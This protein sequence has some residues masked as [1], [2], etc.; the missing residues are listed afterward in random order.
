MK[1]EKR[2][3]VTVLSAEIE[4]PLCYHIFNAVSLL[5]ILFCEGSVLT[6]DLIFI[7]MPAPAYICS[8]LHLPQQLMPKLIKEFKW[9]I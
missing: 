6:P 2:K 1:K 7:E 8:A 5:Y 4:S 3:S 9:S